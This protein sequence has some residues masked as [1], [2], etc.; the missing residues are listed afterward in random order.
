MPVISNFLGIIISIYWKEH[1]PPHFHVKYG[2]HKAEI[3]IDTLEIRAGKLPSRILAFVV[4]W[5][6]LHREELRENWNL[7][8]EKKDLNKIEPLV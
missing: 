7:A 8:Q 1:N 6:I 4:E 3:D 5:A 2:E